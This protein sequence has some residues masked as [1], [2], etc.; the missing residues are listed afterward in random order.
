MLVDI[1]KPVQSQFEEQFRRL[2]ALS[3]GHIWALIARMPCSP[4]L[5]LSVYK[6][7][8]LLLT[9]STN[10]YP[11]YSTCMPCRAGPYAPDY[12]C[13]DD[14]S[15]ISFYYVDDFNFGIQNHL[16]N[17]DVKMKLMYI[18]WNPGILGFLMRDNNVEKPRSDRKCVYNMSGKD[19]LNP[20]RLW[21]P[22]L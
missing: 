4:G 6:C 5:L 8:E 7:V 22:L 13:C 18:T 1:F 3:G 15:I 14:H 21:E 19:L 9:H 2:E 11:F 16:F 20:K 17:I 12:R 10:I